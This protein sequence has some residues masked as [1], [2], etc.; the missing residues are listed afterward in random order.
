MSQ[1]PLAPKPLALVV[2]L[3]N[4]GHIHGVN[5]PLW[6]N[7]VVDFVTEEY[8]KLLLRL[9]G[10][11]RRYDRVIVLED[12]QATPEDLFHALCQTS[13][14]HRVDQLHLVHGQPGALIGYQGKTLIGPDFFA[15]LLAVKARDPQVLDLRMVYGLNCYGLTLAPTWLKL[16]AVAVNGATGV[17]WLPEP[18][19]SLFLHH[20]LQGATFTQSVTHSHALAMQMGRFIWPHSPDGQESPFLAGSHQVIYGRQD[21]SIASV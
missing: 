10:A 20:W 14:S 3:E 15:E 2:L 5:L 1:H 9:R 16:G 11:H 19:L 13:R 18:S 4:V 12:A 21:L 6:A 8:A 7:R 17:N